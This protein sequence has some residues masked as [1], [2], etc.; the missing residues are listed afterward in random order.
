MN[1]R[2][3]DAFKI[4]YSYRIVRGVRQALPGVWAVSVSRANTNY[5]PFDFKSQIRGLIGSRR[6]R[7]RRGRPP[8]PL[9]RAGRLAAEAS[10]FLRVPYPKG[11]NV[12]LKLSV[13]LSITGL[14]LMSHDS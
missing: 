5:K 3:R 11:K 1:R 12:A 6:L 4:Y 7:A 14:Y 9:P 8:P 2:V 13:C 10:I